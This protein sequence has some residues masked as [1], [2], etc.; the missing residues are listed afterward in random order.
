MSYSFMQNSAISR[1]M[2]L[3]WV[4]AMENGPEPRWLVAVARRP[5]SRQGSTKRAQ[6]LRSARPCLQ[7]LVGFL[8]ELQA[9]N[10]H[11]YLHQQAIDATIPSGRA[12]F[13]MCGVFAEFESAFCA[14]TRA[15]RAY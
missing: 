13:Q 11:P 2:S 1:A 12:M 5:I 10:C 8:N 4:K 15:A 14:S 7:H 9:L 3:R 6:T